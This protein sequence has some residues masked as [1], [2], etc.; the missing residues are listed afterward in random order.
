MLLH[1]DNPANRGLL[2]ENLLGIVPE[3]KP[4]TANEPF[5]ILDNSVVV[6]GLIPNGPAEKCDGKVR[7]GDIIRSLDGHHVTIGKKRALNNIVSSKYL[8]LQYYIVDSI[9]ITLDW[10]FYEIFIKKN[11]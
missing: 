9:T 2:L 5:E 10:Q 6:S 1:G 11:R 4:L 8:L 3:A 7:A